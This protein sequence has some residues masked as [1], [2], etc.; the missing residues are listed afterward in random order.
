[1]PPSRK[2]MEIVRFTLMP[3]ME[4]ASLSWATAR[5]ALP[6]RVLEIK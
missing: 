5:I 2:V 1:M 4:A 6:W 3:I